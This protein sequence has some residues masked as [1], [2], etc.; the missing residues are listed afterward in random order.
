MC[1]TI[2][3]YFKKFSEHNVNFVMDLLDNFESL[4]SYIYSVHT[5]PGKP[6]KPRKRLIPFFEKKSG[7]PGK[8]PWKSVFSKKVLLVLDDSGIFFQ[9]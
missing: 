6:G 8:Q 1:V 7:K 2:T 5:A 9:C 4:K 3:V